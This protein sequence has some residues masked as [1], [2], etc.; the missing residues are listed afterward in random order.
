MIGRKPESV[1]AYDMDTI[2]EEVRRI[3]TLMCEASFQLN[4]SEDLGTSMR[5]TMR[6]RELEVYLQGLRFAIGEG[7]P[8]S[9]KS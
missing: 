5:L 8:L 1:I 7:P 2:N 3:E 4:E 9:D 6:Y